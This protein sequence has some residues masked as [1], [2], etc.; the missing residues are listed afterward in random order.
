MVNK[1]DLQSEIN[2]QKA[3]NENLQKQVDNLQGAYNKLLNANDIVVGQ[4]KNL[5]TEL[6]NEIMKNPYTNLTLESLY[7]SPYVDSNVIN[8]NMSIMT[9]QKLAGLSSD[10]EAIANGKQS[11]SGVGGNSV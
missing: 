7:S 2:K 4:N 6:N 10:L 3:I 1:K 11:N 9:K 5:Q 8:T